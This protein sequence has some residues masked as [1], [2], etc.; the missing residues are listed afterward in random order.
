MTAFVLV[1]GMFT[2]AHVWEE[3][4]AR[5]AAA[6]AEVHA[7]ALNGLDGPGGAAGR[8]STWRRTSRTCLR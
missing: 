4:A 6:G 3:A 1:S 5:L 2:G 7:V 8:V